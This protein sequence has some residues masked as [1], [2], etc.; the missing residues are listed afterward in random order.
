[1]QLSLQCAMQNMAETQ[2]NLVWRKGTT[3]APATEADMSWTEQGHGLSGGSCSMFHLNLAQVTCCHSTPGAINLSC[4]Q[5][6]IFIVTGLVGPSL[7]SE[8]ASEVR[9]HGHLSQKWFPRSR[10]EASV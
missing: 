8:P 7:G 1:M 10:T 4:S 9:S 3:L 6:G 5:C 2:V